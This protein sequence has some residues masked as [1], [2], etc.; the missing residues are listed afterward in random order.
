MCVNS[1]SAEN[2]CYCADDSAD[3]AAAAAVAELLLLLLL[4]ASSLRNAWRCLKFLALTWLD[5]SSR[6]TRAGAQPRRRS[7]WRSR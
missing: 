4:L 7:E 1:T 3:F 5:S 6:T 2:F